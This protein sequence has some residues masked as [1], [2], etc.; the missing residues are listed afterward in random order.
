MHKT[1]PKILVLLTF[2]FSGGAQVYATEHDHEHEHEQEHEHH[3]A[4]VH[5]EAQLLIAREGNT[6]E[7]GFFS[8]SMNIVGFEHQPENETQANMVKSAMDSL[9]QPGLLFSFPSSAKCEPVS[10]D[11]ESPFAGHDEHEHEHEEEEHSDFSGHYHYRCADPSRLDRMDI[12]LFS[13]F[14]GTEAI[15]AQVISERGQW[16]QEM[17]P[18]HATLEF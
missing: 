14:P 13:R 11:I 8:P 1:T 18:G 16:K 15:E 4:H 6:L 2:L 10:V 12:Q 9:K 5:G 7:I 17:T 3:E